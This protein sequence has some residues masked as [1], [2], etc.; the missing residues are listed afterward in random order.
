MIPFL[1]SPL[2]TELDLLLLTS[3]LSSTSPSSQFHSCLFQSSLHPVSD[4][5]PLIPY[6]M[7]V[8]QVGL[9]SLDSRV[10]TV[11]RDA[12][13]ALDSYYKGVVPPILPEYKKF[14]DTAKGEDETARKR[15]LDDDEEEG[16]SYWPRK[17]VM[18]EMPEMHV[19]AV[20]T[21]VEAHVS[22]AAVAAVE[23]IEEQAVLARS[24]RKLFGDS[25]PVVASQELNVNE[26]AAEGNVEVPAASP[27]DQDHDQEELDMAPTSSEVLMDVAP[28]NIVARTLPATVSGNVNSRSESD[29]DD[30]DFPMIVVSEDETD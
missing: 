25:R 14:V 13:M 2:R 9:S 17:R 12:L 6:A 8:F 16:D 21:S 26:T 20:E 15:A 10:Q 5:T 18:V 24:T 28:T 27:L 4:V 3:C 22:N 23:S 7:Q 19:E 30:E 11:A 1:S 29:E